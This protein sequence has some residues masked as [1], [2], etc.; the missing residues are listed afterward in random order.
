MKVG[1]MIVYIVSNHLQ[2]GN[3]DQS[4]HPG[5]I[6]RY[7]LHEAQQAYYYGL[8][9]NVALASVTTTPAEVLGLDHRIGTIK[10]GAS[11]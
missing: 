6:S 3:A 7:L 1:G 4:D 2:Q 8:P 11:F 9:K 5:I 10:K